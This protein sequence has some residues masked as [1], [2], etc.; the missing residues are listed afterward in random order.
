M[1]KVRRVKVLLVDTFGLGLSERLHERLGDR[2]GLF[3][4]LGE[5]LD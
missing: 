5:M 2:F 1:C 4:R 3:Y